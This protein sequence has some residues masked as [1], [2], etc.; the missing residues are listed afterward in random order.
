MITTQTIDLSMTPEITVL[1][2]V[3]CS[4]YDNGIRQVVFNLFEDAEQTTPYNVDGLT[5]IVQG[6]KPDNNAYAVEAQASGSSVTVTITTQM[7]AVAG[8]A[9][10]EIVLIA[11]DTVQ[12]IGSLNFLLMVEPA[13]ILDDAVVSDSEIP[14]YVDLA[15]KEAAAQAEAWANGTRGGVPVPDTDPAYHNN[16]KYWSEESPQLAEAWANGTKNGVPVP[17]TDPAYHNN[18][19]YWSAQTAGQTI[20]GLRDVDLPTPIPDGSLL[21]YNEASKKWTTT[22]TPLT[23][24]KG[25]TGNILGLVQSGQDPADEYGLGERATAEG[26]NT[27]ARGMYAH[28]EGLQSKAFGRYSHAEGQSQASGWHSHAEGSGSKAGGNASHTEGTSTETQANN[29][30]AGGL[31]VIAKFSEEF[32]HGQVYKSNDAL[33]HK[34]RGAMPAGIETR[35]FVFGFSP[36]YIADTNRTLDIKGNE[37][38]DLTNGGGCSATLSDTGT[39]NITLHVGAMYL[40]LCSSFTVAT[41]AIYGATA[42]LVT[43]L[44]LAT[45][46]PNV[47]SLAQTQYAPATITAAA[48]NVITIQNA[49]AAR[50]TQFTLIRVA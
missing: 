43:A 26:Y 5:A 7:A 45:G 44:P 25:G 13:G 23:I 39:I 32:I 3:Y 14:G 46:T 49:A 29:A 33:Y 42:R 19:K 15:V 10:S 34:F 28:A 22:E 1:P 17:D 40:L 50:A 11:R 21:L 4:Q 41:G 18:A 8:I 36:D 38:V 20:D 9:P 30:H 47:L 24:E 31:S 35:G 27:S 6:T 2:E 12:R 37:N 16:S 48:N